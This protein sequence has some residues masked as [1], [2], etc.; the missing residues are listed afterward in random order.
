MDEHE[1][2]FGVLLS[3]EIERL[4]NDGY[5]ITKETFEPANL[6]SASYDLRLGADCVQE[7]T[8]VHLTEDNPNLTIR[9][10]QLVFVS[11]FEQLNMPRNVVARYDLRLGLCHQGIGLQVGTQ[12]DPGYQGRLY[13]PLFNFSNRDVPLRLK[14]H[15]T[16]IE[17]TYTTTPTE[18][19]RHWTGEARGLPLHPPQSGLAELQMDLDEFRKQLEDKMN[20]AITHIQQDEINTRSDLVDRIRDTQARVDSMVGAVL[21]LMAMIIAALGLIVVPGQITAAAQAGADLKLVVGVGVVAVLIIGIASWTIVH[22]FAMGRPGRQPP[23][24]D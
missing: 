13:S 12:I 19:S 10:Y 5:L 22:L 3:D 1:H 9:P 24:N 18:K 21:T 16:T 4:V 17:F 23:K 11:T 15:F 2:N 14:E 20:V 6:K 8:P 7:G